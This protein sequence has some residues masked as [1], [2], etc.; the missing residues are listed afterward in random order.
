MKKNTE[1]LDCMMRKKVRMVVIF[2]VMMAVFLVSFLPFA[3]GRLSFDA[4]LFVEWNPTAQYYLLASCLIVYK[5]SSIFNP[6]L[7]LTLKDDYHKSVVLLRK[8]IT[9]LRYF[10]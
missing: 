4:G 1:T 2:S 7:T 9:R 3:L 6:L 5:S 8:G 10:S